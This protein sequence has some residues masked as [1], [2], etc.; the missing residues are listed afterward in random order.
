MKKF[1]VKSGLVAIMLACSA[2]SAQAEEAVKA[3]KALK[4][5]LL[6]Y[7]GRPNPTFVVTDAKEIKEILSL[8]NAIPRKKSFAGDSNLQIEGKLGYQGFLVTNNSDL[9]SELK[10]FFVRGNNV[11]MELISGSKALGKTAVE[12]ATAVDSNTRLES[13]LL[14]SAKAN[15]IADEKLL[16]VIEASK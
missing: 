1:I 8:A 2:L 16:K 13:K 3:V 7:S 12:Q 4:V 5:E 9:N 10:T 11:Q 6:V 15:G 14:N